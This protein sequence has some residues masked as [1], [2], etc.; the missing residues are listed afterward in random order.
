MVGE[1]QSERPGECVGGDVMSLLFELFMAEHPLAVFFNWAE[2][3]G[4]CQRSCMVLCLLY[5]CCHSSLGTLFCLL[6][7]CCLC[8]WCDSLCAAEAGPVA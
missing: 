6:F 2:V 4:T 3:T 7:L 1:G 8:M 5:V